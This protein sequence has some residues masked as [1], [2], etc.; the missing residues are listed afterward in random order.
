MDNQERKINHAWWILRAVFGVVPVV[1]G[2]DKFFNLLTQWDRYLS[3][4]AVHTLPLSG[5]ALLRIVGVVEIVVGVLVLTRWTRIGAYIASA[6][7][8]VIALNLLTTG[9]YFDIA[10]RDVALA[11]AAFALAQLEEARVGV[12]SRPVPVMPIPERG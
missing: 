5:F 6:W 9:Q 12:V 11:L 10:A 8:L 3:P 7:L 1:A 2:L 4:I